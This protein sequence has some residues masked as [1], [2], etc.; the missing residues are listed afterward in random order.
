M[1]SY[2]LTLE[3]KESQRSEPNPATLP[4]TSASQVIILII[5]IQLSLY[6]TY[7]T[8]EICIVGLTQVIFKLKLEFI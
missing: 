3:M 1:F 4:I 6:I 8:N 5:I 7:S 2:Q